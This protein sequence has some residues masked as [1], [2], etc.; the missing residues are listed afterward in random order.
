MPLQ[1]SNKDDVTPLRIQLNE[2]QTEHRDLDFVI[3]HLTENPPS[4][5]LL[6]R[7]L[8]KRKLGLK[9]KIMQLEQCLIP[10]IPA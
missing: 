10:D 2:L 4:D 1:T 9:D 3:T 5:D 8:K 7:R 6:V